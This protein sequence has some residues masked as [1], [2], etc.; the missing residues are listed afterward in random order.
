MVDNSVVQFN[1][2]GKL[3][4][5]EGNVYFGLSFRVGSISI[6]SLFLCSLGQ[7][8]VPLLVTLTRS[9]TMFE[10]RLHSRLSNYLIGPWMSNL[11]GTG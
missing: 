8:V 10:S 11:P 2:N 3:H 7:R 6:T 4:S 1:I 9:F 5:L